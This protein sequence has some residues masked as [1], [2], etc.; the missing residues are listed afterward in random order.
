ME[1]TQPKRINRDSKIDFAFREET[2]RGRL[3][4]GKDQT[5]RE[6][7]LGRSLPL[8]LLGAAI[9]ILGTFCTIYWLA[10]L[11]S[12]IALSAVCGVGC[13]YGAKLNGNSE[14]SSWT[15]VMAIQLAWFGLFGVEPG[16]DIF[17]AMPFIVGLFGLLG[18][19][20]VAAYAADR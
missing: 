4:G 1:P 7:V 19:A 11:Q 12:I 16:V 15:V 14:L 13:Y 8:P 6:L 9:V 3:F 17:G 10:G 2:P 5:R 18:L 20:A